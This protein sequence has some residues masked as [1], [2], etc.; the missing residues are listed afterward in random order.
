MRSAISPRLA[1]S[2]RAL[3]RSQRLGTAVRP[4]APHLHA[5][6]ANWDLSARS[7]W[8]Q[9]LGSRWM[10]YGNRS[11]Y[12]SRSCDCAAMYGATGKQSIASCFFSSRYV[13]PSKATGILNR[14]GILRNFT[15]AEA[16]Q[17]QRRLFSTGGL[18]QRQYVYRTF[19]QGARNAPHIQYQGQDND[20]YKKKRESKL[21]MLGCVAFGVGFYVYNLDRVPVCSLH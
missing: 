14:N 11:A 17:S 18:L 7:S 21:W 12:G 9:N 10:S 8:T 2:S 16:I 4:L 15:T 13:L 6:V 3:S 1:L 19:Q 20:P 5:A